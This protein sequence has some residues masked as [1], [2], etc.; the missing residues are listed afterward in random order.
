MTTAIQEDEPD[1]MSEEYDPNI[2]GGKRGGYG[3]EV[4]K[5]NFIF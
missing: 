1:P 4:S 2:Y 3:F 5:R